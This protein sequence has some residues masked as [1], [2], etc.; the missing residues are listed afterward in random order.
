MNA[1][2]SIRIRWFFIILG[3]VFIRYVMPI[4]G[5]IFF[6]GMF[7]LGVFWLRDPARDTAFVI[8]FLIGSGIGLVLSLFLAFVANRRRA[9]HQWR[10]WRDPRMNDTGDT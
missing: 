3:E 6:A 7:A 4:C 8:Q 10:Q 9:R 2:R 5:V 1:T